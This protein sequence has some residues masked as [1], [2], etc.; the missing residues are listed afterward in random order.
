MKT[1]YVYKWTHIPTLKWYVG[2]RTGKKAHPDDGYICSS[3]LVKPMVQ[4][5]P[6]EWKREIIEVGT[7]D[8]MYNLETEILQLVDARNDPRS[9]N[10]TNNKGLSRT[11]KTGS[12]HSEES[13]RKMKE[14]A[15][16]KIP[17]KNFNHSEESKQKI[18]LGLIGRVFS[19][20]H[21]ARIGL[22]H[23]NKIVSE[24]TKQ[25]LRNSRPDAHGEN[26]PMFGIKQ[27]DETKEKIRQKALGRKRS[28]E[29]IAKG[30]QT[31]LEKKRTL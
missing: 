2:S 29:S 28:P 31:R 9:F 30:L 5:N 6:T 16:H 13:K 27:S 21:K 25:K 18:S 11:D 15:K 3:L 8:E 4:S 24:E 19:P 26:N 20:E 1:A 10:K 22:V 14:A 12:V 7:P 17:R 23:K